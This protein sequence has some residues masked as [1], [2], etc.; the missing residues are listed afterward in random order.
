MKNYTKLLREHH[1]KVTPQRVAIADILYTKGHISIDSL[2][3]IMLKKFDSISLATIYKN[4]N[5][6]TQNTFIQEVKIPNSKSVYELTKASHAHLVCEQCSSV[7]DIDFDVE[8]LT[9]YASSI[10][11][12]DVESVN[13]IFTGM[14]IDCKETYEKKEYKG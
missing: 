13:V 12:F 11:S 10:K 7:E 1:L 4:V 8:N 5:I 6:M 3:E 2:Y 14:C 9:K